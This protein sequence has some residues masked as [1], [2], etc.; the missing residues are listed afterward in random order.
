M[1]VFSSAAVLVGLHAMAGVALA[2]SSA[3]MPGPWWVHA[4]PVQVQFHTTAAVN[5]GG[6]V[7]PGGGADANNNTTL[8]LEIGRD[9]T[10]NLAARLTV[11]VPPRTTLTGTGTLQGAGELGRVKYGPAV[12]SATWAFD[13]LGAV[14]P[15]IG[16]GVNYTVVLD[17][18]DGSITSLK[19]KN[20]FGSVLQAGFDIPLGQRWGLFLDVKKV[21]L[22]TTADGFV[23][24]AP[25]SASVRLDPLL[26][27]GGVSYRF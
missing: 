18:Q 16:A 8:G 22:K 1:K 7:V 5:L 11:G 24:T 10:P 12:L 25:A 15:Y 13:G 9:L 21:F 23:G 17:S 3:D 6:A 19:V 26:I 14:R 2:Q 27:H 20:A 4:G